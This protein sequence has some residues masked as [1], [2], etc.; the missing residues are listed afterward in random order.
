V[1]SQDKRRGPA[2][3]PLQKRQ[4]AADTQQS[5]PAGEL[6]PGRQ[7][8]KAVPFWDCPIPCPHPSICTEDGTQEQL[9]DVIELRRGKR[10]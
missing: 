5:T 7:D 3:G 4:P 10:R 9:A 8:C 6:P 1:S 2:T